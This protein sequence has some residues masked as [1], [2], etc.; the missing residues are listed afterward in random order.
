MCKSLFFAIA[1]LCAGLAHSQA[2]QGDVERGR[3]VFAACRTCHY[4][5]QGFGHHNG[6]NLFQVFGKRLGSTDFAHYSDVLKSSGLVVTPELLDAWIAQ[7]QHFLKGNHMVA[8]P[9]TKPQDRADL[10][11]Y[12][13]QFR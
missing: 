12:L 8:P 7:P 3:L 4:P 6:P 2:L 13:Q 9:M 1:A 10:I 5:E 11:A